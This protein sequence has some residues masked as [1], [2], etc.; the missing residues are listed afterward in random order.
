MIKS[1]V[2]CNGFLWEDVVQHQNIIAKVYAIESTQ[3]FEIEFSKAKHSIIL[4]MLVVCGL[5][6]LIYPDFL[7]QSYDYLSV[8]Q[9][10]VTIMDYY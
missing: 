7:G 3:R 6:R 8:L 1:S 4:Y 2:K 10:I 5:V 9:V